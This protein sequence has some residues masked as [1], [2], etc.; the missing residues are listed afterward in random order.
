M[1]VIP[2]GPKDSGLFADGSMTR[3]RSVTGT[4]A[5]ADV[6]RTRSTWTLACV[7]RPCTTKGSPKSAVPVSAGD[8]IV[9]FGSSVRCRDANGLLDAWT[10]RQGTG[11]VCS[12]SPPGSSTYQKLSRSSTAS[13]PA[14]F[15][16]A[17]RSV[18]FG[19]RG[20][21][22]IRTNADCG[23]TPVRVSQIAWADWLGEA[24]TLD[25]SPDPWWATTRAAPPPTDRTRTW[26]SKR[27]LGVDPNVTSTRRSRRSDS[28]VVR[29][30]EPRSRRRGGAGEDSVL[31]NGTSQ[32]RISPLPPVRWRRTKAMWSRHCTGQASSTPG[33]EIASRLSRRVARL[34]RY[35][36][37]PLPAAVAQRV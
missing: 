17:R 30:Q 7:S 16:Q 6:L 24:N 1:T 9:S 21:R 23:C 28:P 5:S 13:A 32:S 25:S 14:S 31:T 37:Q 26:L 11:V 36:S 2:V 33:A 18:F 34:R 22:S 27:S 4:P 35:M 10:S 19:V 3:R 8:A 20:C 15:V 12:Q 29:A